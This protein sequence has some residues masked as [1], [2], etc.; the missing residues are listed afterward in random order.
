MSQVDG[1]SL[2]TTSRHS[3]QRPA[4]YKWLPV[5]KHTSVNF[6]TVHNARV[7]T[8]RTPA[9]PPPKRK[10]YFP[11]HAHAASTL[12]GHWG[13]GAKKAARFLIPIN[14]S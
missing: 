10:T 12:H 11:F 3:T 8:T 5:S 13:G 14:T 4:V 2:A 9:P 7:M 6:L 1:R